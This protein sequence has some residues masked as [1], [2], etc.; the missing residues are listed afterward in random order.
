MCLFI[1]VFACSARRFIQ[2]PN[3]KLLT[4]CLA[5]FLTLTFTQVTYSADAPLTTA[6]LLDFLRK[7]PKAINRTSKKR[8]AI[9]GD[10]LALDLWFGLSRRYRK[11]KNVEFLRFTKS[12]TGL[13]RDDVYDWNQKLSTFIRSKSFDVAV[14]VMGGNDRQPIRVDGRRLKRRSKAWLKEYRARVD[15]LTKTL[16]SETRIIYW[17]GLPIVQSPG[18]ARDFGQF[19]MI[20]ASSAM[21]HRINYINIWPL[22]RDKNGAFTSFGPDT[23][24]AKRRLRNDDGLHFTV[25][26]QDRLAQVVAKEINR[27]VKLSANAPARSNNVH[28]S[29]TDTVSTSGAVSLIQEETAHRPEM[30]QEPHLAGSG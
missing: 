28:Q 12:A 22:F 18:M 5:A 20:Y 27:R 15:H 19:N 1:R 17:V 9:I 25:A 14:V 11:N 2:T 6:G 3:H 8:V 10:S 7:K 24:G 13:V 21:A 4:A 29:E 26:G 16:K 30:L 23:R